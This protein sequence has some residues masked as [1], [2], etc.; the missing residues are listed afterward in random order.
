MS[1]APAAFSRQHRPTWVRPHDVRRR[2]SQRWRSWRR[3]PKVTRTVGFR[4]PAPPSHAPTAPRRTNEPA[5]TTSDI[6]GAG[7]NAAIARG[8]AAS[9]AQ[10]NADVGAACTALAVVS[11]GN[12]NSSR[13]W[14]SNVPLAVR[15]SATCDLY[16]AKRR[17]S[18]RNTSKRLAVE[19]ITSFTPRTVTRGPP[20]RSARCCS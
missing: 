14:T 3:D 13:A 5:D 4:T 1:A 12:P 15:C 18:S 10:D 7:A 11:G 8:E 17:C 19:M 20:T 9:I 2:Q 6:A 16:L